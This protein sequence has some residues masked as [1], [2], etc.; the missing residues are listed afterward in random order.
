MYNKSLKI[1]FFSLKLSVITIYI[2][3]IN[4]LFSFARFNKAKNQT[5][6]WI[7]IF[8][9]T[10]L[11]NKLDAQENVKSAWRLTIDVSSEQ[12]LNDCKFF[13]GDTLNEFN[14][15][16]TIVKV[17]NVY[18]SYTE[19][20][21]CV[22]K[23]EAD[24]VKSKYNIVQLPF[25]SALIQNEP[26]LSLKSNSGCN[27]VDFE[28]GDFTGW[29]GGKGYNAVSI[30]PLSIFNNGIYTLGADAPRKSCSYHTIVT[31]ASGN[32]FYG[33]YPVLC[34]NGGTYSVRLGGDNVNIYNG[35][36]CNN[37]Y[38]C[39]YPGPDN[40]LHAAGEVLT[41]SFTVSATNTLFTFYYAASLND[42]GHEPGEQPYFAIQVYDS[43]GNPIN[44]F[45]H[46][47]ELVAGVIPPG[48]ELSSNGNCIYSSTSSDYNV[49]SIPWQS[50]SYN[51]SAYIGQTL[52]VKFT[53]AG[54][55][56]GGHFGIGVS[57]SSF[58]NSS[59]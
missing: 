22:F 40:P 52:T 15:L 38:S 42:G 49:Y 31:S 58:C 12:M 27:N 24:F 23:K 47:I 26:V 57:L 53:A 55:T 51:L 19:V 36:D 10:F 9:F 43:L 25:E 59:N 17:K 20:K 21:S 13:G 56:Y 2:I 32:D 3:F 7:F 34:P 41:Q 28:D 39:G 4:C 14:L 5:Y 29:T 46:R 48:G 54:C 45:S 37:S 30:D 44:C 1:E 50:D 8:L 35:T 33:N 18:N 11:L 6:K 16:D